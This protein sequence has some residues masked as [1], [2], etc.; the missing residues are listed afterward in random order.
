M[1]LTITTTN[2]GVC[3][4][5][6][7]VGDRS[8]RRVITTTGEVQGGEILWAA[9]R[10]PAR[11]YDTHWQVAISWLDRG[12]GSVT[13]KL[14]DLMCVAYCCSVLR[15]GSVYVQLLSSG[16]VSLSRVCVTLIHRYV[17]YMTALPQLYVRLLVARW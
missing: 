7:R 17:S 1:C 15:S 10:C 13:V 14:Q 6:R 5:V 4:S 12:R 9:G 8:N 3:E 16:R 11:E 2:N